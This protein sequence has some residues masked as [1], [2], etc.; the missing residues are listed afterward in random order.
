MTLIFA[1]SLQRKNQLFYAQVRMYIAH[2]Q[3]ILNFWSYWIL[4]FLEIWSML[5]SCQM[6]ILLYIVLLVV[7]RYVQGPSRQI[8]IKSSNKEK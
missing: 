3:N 2:L 5:L 1:A 4:E 6:Y 8:E 7:T